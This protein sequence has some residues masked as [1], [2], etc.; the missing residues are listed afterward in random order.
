MST[1]SVPDELVAKLRMLEDDERS[2]VGELVTRVLSKY[3]LRADPA[4]L[5]ARVRNIE[6]ELTRVGISEEELAENFTQWR[7]RGRPDG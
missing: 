1:V 7:R 4:E 6:A 2:D 5:L 3:I